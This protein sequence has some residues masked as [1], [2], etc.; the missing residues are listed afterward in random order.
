MHYARIGIGSAL[1]LVLIGVSAFCNWRFGLS[2]ASGFD[3]QI[4]A[5]LGA[6]ADLFKALVPL[7]I[8]AA[9]AARERLR[10]IVGVVVFG[11]L[12][13]Y[14]LASAIG[15]Y[16]LSRENA[17]SDVEVVQVEHQRLTR[18][19]TRTREELSEL[20]SV[21]LPETVASAI[22]ATKHDQIYTRSGECTDATAKSSRDLCARLADLKGE[23]AIAQEAAAL[24]DRIRN[25]QANLSGLDMDKVLR[26]ADPQAEALARLTGWP[27]M[28]VRTGL[29]LLIAVLIE[30]GSG[31]GLWLA[32]AGSPGPA[33]AFVSRK[34][35]L[36]NPIQGPIVHADGSQMPLLENS[37]FSANDEFTVETWAADRIERSLHGQVTPSELRDDYAAWCRARGGEPVSDN[38][39]GRDLSALGLVRKRTGGRTLYLGIGLVERN[40]P[41]LQVVR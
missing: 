7:M 41:A 20:G 14:S 32:T 17:V 12:T 23:L 27:P 21:R 9:W 24:R 35:G 16:S 40:P 6:S 18:E 34:Q 19:L 30:L 5:L 10:A 26:S 2:L 39:F 36:Q 3:A 22:A 13:T 1:A 29:A 33:Q 37:G 11:V 25:L 28:D 38:K 15:L 4:Y 31:L 8:A